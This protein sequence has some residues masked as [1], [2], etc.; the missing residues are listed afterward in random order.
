MGK[1]AGNQATAASVSK[2]AKVDPV[3]TSIADAIMEAEELPNRCRTMLVNV[4]PFT[5]KLPS[6][7]R[8]EIQTA[9]L[10]MVKQTLSSKKS[11]IESSVAAEEAKLTNLQGSQ[12][13]LA[14]A[15]S[16]AEAATATQ[17]DTVEAAK[18]L[19]TDATAAANASWDALTDHREKQ[20]ITVAKLADVKAEKASLEL[21]FTEH[22]MPMKEEAAGEHYQ[23]LEPYLKNIEIEAT[24]LIALPSSCSKSKDQRGSFDMVVLEELGKALSSKLAALGDAVVDQTPMCVDCETAAYAAQEEYDAKKDTQKRAAADFE[25]AQK[26][27]SV[28]E[29]TLR[30]ARRS[31]KELQPQMDSAVEVIEKAQAALEAFKV[32]PLAGFET[33]CALGAETAEAATAGA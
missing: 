30:E 3:L 4:L 12:G 9:V 7:E 27:H 15:V 5:L 16:Q 23:G 25:A 33:Y 29:A 14:N 1:R 20:S 19:L 6:D 32:G 28:R 17:K 13:E 11:L 26:E 10:D 24:L 31:V 18:L 2:K 22:F 8:H 21:A